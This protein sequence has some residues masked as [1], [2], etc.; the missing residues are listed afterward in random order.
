MNLNKLAQLITEAEGKTEQVN[1]AQ[2]K[3]VLSVLA[4]ILVRNPLYLGALL[5]NGMKKK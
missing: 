2:V 4:R 5:V 3:E 1:I